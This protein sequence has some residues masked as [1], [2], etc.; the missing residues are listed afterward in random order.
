[1]EKDIKSLKNK[2]QAVLLVY[3]LTE[4]DEWEIGDLLYYMDEIDQI[5]FEENKKEKS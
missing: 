2:L 3:Y 5:I 4:A 1:M